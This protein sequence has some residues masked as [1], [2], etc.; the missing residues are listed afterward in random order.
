MAFRVE[1]EPQVLE[2]LESIAAFIQINSSFAVA[3]K[4]FN[5]AMADIHSLKKLPG[6]CPIAQQL[7]EFGHQIRILLNGRAKRAYKIYY[8]IDFETPSSGVVRVLHLRVILQ[9]IW[10]KSLRAIWH[11]WFSWLMLTGRGADRLS[12]GGS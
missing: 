6:R 4:W 12:P 11:G 2:D 3:E 10:R 9:I 1:I 8:L 5:R 7:E